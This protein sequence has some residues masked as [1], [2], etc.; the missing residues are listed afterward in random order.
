MV[1]AQCAYLVGQQLLEGRNRTGCIP[2]LPLET[3]ELDPSDEGA[4][5]VRSLYAYLVGQQLL[6]GRSRTGC[7][8]AFFWRRASST[9]VMK[10]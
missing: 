2:R 3:G 8:P 10:M 1:R 6:E 5:V 4:A 7:I 9:R